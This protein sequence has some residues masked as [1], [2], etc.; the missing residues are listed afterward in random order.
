MLDCAVE[1][2]KHLELLVGVAFALV[3]LGFLVM[4]AWTS[5]LLSAFR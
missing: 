5:G 4:M 2:K 3:L 1:M